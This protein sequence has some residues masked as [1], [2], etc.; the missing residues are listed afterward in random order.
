MG[1]ENTYTRED[2]V[3]GVKTLIFACLAGGF[4][5]YVVMYYGVRFLKWALGGC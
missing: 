3:R 2:Y 5:W 4:I 1:K